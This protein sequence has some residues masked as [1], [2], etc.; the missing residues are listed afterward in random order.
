MAVQWL[1][2][3]H[4]LP[5]RNSPWHRIANGGE[6]TQTELL[7]KF[8]I[9][10]VCDWPG[11]SQPVAIVHYAQ[12]TAD[13]FKA[14]SRT[15]IGAITG[16]SPPARFE[17]G[18]AESEARAKQNPKQQASAGLETASQSGEK[19]LLQPV[20]AQAVLQCVAGSDEARASRAK[21]EGMGGTRL[22]LVTSTMST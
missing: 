13:D 3:K 6:L 8:P 21:M 9:K 4:R 22:E 20:A 5:I 18:E 7:H 14:A 16:E 2:H 11:N 15:P 12:V 1:R 10:A 17:S 19:E